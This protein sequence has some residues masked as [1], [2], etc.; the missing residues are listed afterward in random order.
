MVTYSH[1]HVAVN[2]AVCI[3]GVTKGLRA[4]YQSLIVPKLVP[5][6]KF[7]AANGFQMF[8]TGTISLIIGP[9]IG[10]NTCI[11]TKNKFDITSN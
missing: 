8:L 1:S 5:L 6:D 7:V 3:I 11:S 10:K 2:V 9:L 4:V